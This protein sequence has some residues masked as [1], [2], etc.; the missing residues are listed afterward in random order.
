MSN[1]SDSSLNAAKVWMYQHYQDLLR[2]SGQNKITLN[3]LSVFRFY[4]C[5][6]FELGII[7]NV[8]RIVFHWNYG[9]RH[10]NYGLS[11]VIFAGAVEGGD[12]SYA[13]REC[14]GRAIQGRA[15]GT[16]VTN[17]AICIYFWIG[18]FLVRIRSEREPRGGRRANVKVARS[19]PACPS[20]FSIRLAKKIIRFYPWKTF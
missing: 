6:N 15:D 10:L 5:L 12:N 18:D 7:S 19:F 2:L 11:L 14:W 20:S 1:H 8:Y 4:L 9:D 17:Q 13:I 3:S 16:L